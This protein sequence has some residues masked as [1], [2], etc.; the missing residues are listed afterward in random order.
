V[1]KVTDKTIQIKDLPS[2]TYYRVLE[3]KA[4]LKAKDWTD[5]MK[6]ILAI[7]EKFKDRIEKELSEADIP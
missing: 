6:K 7:L 2:S 3:W 1:T 4:K 5:F